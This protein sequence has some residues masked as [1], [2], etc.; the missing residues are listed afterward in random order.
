MNNESGLP[1]RLHNLDAL[2][3]AAAVFVVIYHLATAKLSIT[4]VPHG[5]L[6]VDLFFILSGI[7]IA[8]A[9]SHRLISGMGFFDFVRARIIRLYPLAVSGAALGLAVLLLKYL[10]SPGKVETLPTILVSSGLN[11]LLL[12]SFFTTDITKFVAFPGNGPLWSLSF[13]VIINLVWASCLVKARTSI[14]CAIT[15]ISGAL[16]AAAVMN[17]GNA[18]LGWDSLTYLAGFPRVTFGFL[19]GVLIHRFRTSN[20]NKAGLTGGMLCALLAGILLMPH[21]LLW[22][23]VSIFILLPLLAYFGSGPSQVKT[24]GGTFLGDLSYPLYVLHF[25]I[26]LITSGIKQT[27]NQNGHSPV[28][29]VIALSITAVLSW[30]MLKQFDEPVRKAWSKRW[31]KQASHAQQAAVIDDGETAEPPLRG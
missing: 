4:F 29:V 14:L 7:V 13:E 21:N 24:S 11:A 5:Y 25:P 16:Y 12:P 28:L 8:H 15:A 19:T 1:T 6:A 3:G 10:V 22:D 27:M 9:Y 31:Q 26:L 17:F 20:E 30:V 23:L 2:R 18:N